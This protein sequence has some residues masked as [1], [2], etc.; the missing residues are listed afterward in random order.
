M[1]PLVIPNTGFERGRNLRSL[2]LNI[3]IPF[4]Q[5]CI[6]FWKNELVKIYSYETISP[7]R[8]IWYQSMVP[9]DLNSKIFFTCAFPV[10]C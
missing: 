4:F 3:N 2:F 7:D 9:R 8:W 5:N 1:R 6:I 10:P